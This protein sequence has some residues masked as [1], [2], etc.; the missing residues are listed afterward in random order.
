[1]DD[2]QLYFL[3]FNLYIIA[4][5]IV[6]GTRMSIFLF[7]FALIMLAMFIRNDIKHQNNEEDI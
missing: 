2:T 1:M 3:L 5:F 6:N 4:S 7:G